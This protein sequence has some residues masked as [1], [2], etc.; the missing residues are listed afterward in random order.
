MAEKSIKHTRLLAYTKWSEQENKAHLDLEEAFLAGCKFGYR[1]GK[2]AKTESP[3]KCLV[4][5][6]KWEESECGWGSR[7]DGYSIH[8]TEADRVAYLKA[9]SDSRHDEVVPDEYSRPDGTPYL[10]E[11][12]KKVYLKLKKCKAKG[13][14]IWNNKYP[15]HGGTDGWRSR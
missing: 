11:I 6:Q 7:P 1:Q 14:H 9:E 8:L 10:A 3:Q 12:D 2:K 4:I 13:L 5:V 15:G